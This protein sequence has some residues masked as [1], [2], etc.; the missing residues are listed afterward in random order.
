[1]EDA[2]LLIAGLFTAFLLIYRDRIL[3]KKVEVSL[4]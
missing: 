4:N 3:S 2:S 1:V